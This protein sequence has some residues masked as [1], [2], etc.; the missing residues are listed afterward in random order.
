M[1]DFL[2]GFKTN[3][4]SKYIKYW[5]GIYNLGDVFSDFLL[6]SIY[7]KKLLDGVSSRKVMMFIGSE[8]PEWTN[9]SRLVCGL[10]W[11][12]KDAVLKNININPANFLY[13]RGKI[14]RQRVIDS[15]INIPNDLPVGDSGLLASLLYEPLSEKKH[16][17]GIITHWS[18]KPRLE[19]YLNIAKNI[20]PDKDI[21]IM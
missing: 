14:S 20:F 7:D 19:Q 15:G 3:I 9:I 10:G 11:R 18:A 17:V 12:E 6:D 13:T 8:I 1:P 5:H 21:V 4:N 16:D 2:N